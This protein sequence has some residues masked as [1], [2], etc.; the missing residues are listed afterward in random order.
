MKKIVVIFLS[1]LFLFCFV[2]CNRSLDSNVGSSND[3]QITPSSNNEINN[4]ISDKNIPY[5]LELYFSSGAGAWCSSII[6]N[7]DGSFSGEHHDSKMGVT[8]K[9]YPNGT[10]YEC[11]FEGKFTN[12]HQINDYTFAL[13]LESIET[14][15]V[16]G[17][18]YIKDGVR[19]ETSF[20]NGLM[21]ND[22]LKPAREFLLYTPETKVSEL[23]DTFLYWCPLKYDNKATD[24]LSLYGLYNKETED[25]FFTIL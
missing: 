14:E 10:V 16:Q 8:G 1:V 4:E 13:T 7:S 17:Y 11:K 23:S 6:I 9:N 2:G 24:N 15:Q 3:L 20:P 5:P 21:G 18:S 12:I 25:G 22:G 19:F